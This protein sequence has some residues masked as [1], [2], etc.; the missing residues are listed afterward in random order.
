[1]DG[2]AMGPVLGGVAGS[3][4]RVGVASF[5]VTFFDEM[6]DRDLVGRTGLGV[7]VS[8]SG[9]ADLFLGDGEGEGRG[10]VKGDEAGGGF[11][12]G[13]FRP[14]PAIVDCSSSFLCPVSSFSSPA[15]TPLFPLLS[16]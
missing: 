1:M 5:D 6:E 12:L 2:P 7:V 9:A 10:A 4:W 16:S 14:Y 13:L 3:L 11:L 8:G 15:S